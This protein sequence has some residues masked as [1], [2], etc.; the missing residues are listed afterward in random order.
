MAL[1]IDIGIKRCAETI[2]RVVRGFTGDQ[3]E[4]GLWARYVRDS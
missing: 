2:P 4:S 3:I 1:G